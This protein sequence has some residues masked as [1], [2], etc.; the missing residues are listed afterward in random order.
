MDRIELRVDSETRT[1][2][3]DVLFLD[4]LVADQFS[5]LIG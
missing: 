3:V 2:V 4:V 1:N 5:Q